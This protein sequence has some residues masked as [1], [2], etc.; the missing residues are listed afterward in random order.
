M[1]LDAI[2][3]NCTREESGELT[4]YVK[5]VDTATG[6]TIKE[7]CE[8]GADADEIKSK[9]RTIMQAEMDKYNSE[10][11]LKDAAQQRLD[12]LKTELGFGGQ[13]S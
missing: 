4:I 12:D 1:T 11:S 10:Q 7:I 6:G 3:D 5:I 13:S 8:S 2:L 9:L